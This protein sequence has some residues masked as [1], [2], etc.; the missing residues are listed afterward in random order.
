[1]TDILIGWK[2]I[3]QYLRVSER[4]AQRYQEKGL[5]VKYDPADHPILPKTS[6][7]EWRMAQIS[8][9]NAPVS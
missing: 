9:K 3:S 4:T 2:E 6:A 1:M 8:D 5:P 7:D